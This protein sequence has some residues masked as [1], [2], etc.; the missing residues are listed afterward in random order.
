ML[1][2]STIAPTIETDRLILR[3]FR[4]SDFD[5][6]ADVCADP[7]ITRFTGGAITDRAVAWEKFLRSP[8]WWSLLGYGLW[9]VEEKETGRYAGNVGFGFFER[10][11]EPPLPHIPEAAWMLAG[12]AH[13]Q[14]Y[15]N[16]AMKAATKWCDDT[17][18]TPQCCIISEANTP[19]RKLAEKLGFREQRRIEFHDEPTIVLERAMR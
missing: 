1:Q 8:G 9:I 2:Q 11:I 13:G 19:S 5:D 18:G 12:W 16:E 14:G 17:I 6:F 4:R 3:E 10:A 15:A 7:D